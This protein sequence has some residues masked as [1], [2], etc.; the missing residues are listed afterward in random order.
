MM[1]KI[2][3]LGAE[4]FPGVDPEKFSQWKEMRMKGEKLMFILWLGM[5]AIFMLLTVSGAIGGFLIAFLIILTPI[6]ARL[7]SLASA[8]RFAS[9]I[10]IEEKNIR[11]ALKRQTS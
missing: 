10:G 1:R 6:F 9:E 7:I 8:N 5:L 2:S 4:E 3:D 11:T